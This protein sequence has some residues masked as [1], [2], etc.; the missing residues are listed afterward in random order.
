MAADV[1]ARVRGEID[2]RLNELRPA[3][4]EH[5][6]LL[7]AAA[8]LEAEAKLRTAAKPR[9]STKL[10]RPAT[11]RPAAKPRAAAKRRAAVKPRAAARPKPARLGVGEQSIVAA[12]EHGSH[13]VAELGVVTAMSGA[14]IRAS[15]R[16]LLSD[17]KVTRARRDG[18]AAYALS[19]TA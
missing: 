15:L 12:L 14:D 7:A 13:T 11:P 1:L 18:R 3:M 9:Q 4:A 2:A 8:A 10:P 17:G 19:G 16:R 6:Q 5:Q